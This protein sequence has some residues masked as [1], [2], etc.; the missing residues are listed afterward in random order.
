MLLWADDLRAVFCVASVP[1]LA[2]VLLLALGVREPETSRPRQPGN[3]IRRADL[4]RLGRAYGWVV[5][6]GAAFTLARFSEA[7][8]VLRAEQVGMR[9]AFV[10]LVMVIMNLAYAATA[11]PFGRL[12]DRTSHRALLAGGLVVLIAADLVL[13]LGAH[14]TAVGVG[15][16]LWGVHM[17]MT[18]GLL[19]TMVAAASPDDLRGTAFGVFALVAGAAMLLASGLAGVL[20]D[21]LGAGATFHAGAGFAALALVG[22]GIRGRWSRSV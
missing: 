10:P 13:G 1:A 6:I 18:Q 11:Y 20:W 9:W 16:A 2:A 4:A 21:R 3:P 12:A 19:A 8:L 7:F 22:L 5:A 15:V 14:W 17:G